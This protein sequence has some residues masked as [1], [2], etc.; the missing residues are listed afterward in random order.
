M[1]HR[2]NELP[3]AW[4]LFCQLNIYVE[5]NRYCAL[6]GLNAQDYSIFTVPYVVNKITLIIL[7]YDTA[8][9]IVTIILLQSD[10]PVCGYYSDYSF[11]VIT[12]T[13]L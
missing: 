7:Y 12:I 3:A 8:I 11:I 6:N 2:L 1:S 10:I 13:L 4:N 9:T 5:C